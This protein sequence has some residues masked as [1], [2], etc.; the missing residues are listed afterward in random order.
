M[1]FRRI[2][3]PEKRNL[4]NENNNNE[5]IENHEAIVE[6]VPNSAMSDW[7][8]GEM[9]NNNNN[10][11]FD[12]RD[13]EPKADDYAEKMEAAKR[14]VEQKGTEEDS[15][16]LLDNALG[17]IALSCAMLR[18]QSR[19][20][21]REELR[22]RCNTKSTL[23][24]DKQKKK[25]AEELRKMKK[26]PSFKRHEELK[27]VMNE[28]EEIRKKKNFQRTKEEIESVLNKTTAWIDQYDGNNDVVDE[29]RSEIAR[30]NWAL[31]GW[32]KWKN[33]LLEGA[34]VISL[35]A[36]NRWMEEI[37]A[38]EQFRKLPWETRRDQEDELCV[39]LLLHI[40]ALSKY[41]DRD[42]ILPKMNDYTS[43]FIQGEKVEPH[44]DEERMKQ[45][46][47]IEEDVDFLSTEILPLFEAS[48]KGKKG[49]EVCKELINL[50]DIERELLKEESDD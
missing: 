17:N 13:S 2:Q 9:N 20:Q 40:K 23:S 35:Y 43:R 5:Q 8:R 48:G 42:S 15:V 31:L 7:L 49:I 16:G 39:A 27:E 50:L 44:S 3:K 34:N 32:E 10:Q 26:Q 19:E 46:N 25:A 38:E 6:Q 45:A 28:L 29:I 21:L 24:L 1:P 18:G 22:S 47:D 4:S 37:E 33:K 12:Q 36:L 30:C 11:Q 41:V 14:E